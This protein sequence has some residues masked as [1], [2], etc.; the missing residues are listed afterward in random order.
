MTVYKKKERLLTDRGINEAYKLYRRDNKSPLAVTRDIYKRVI[1]ECNKA[2]L[3]KILYESA[4]FTLPFKLGELRIKKTRQIYI[5][6]HLKIDWEA[7]KKL[8]KRV[9]H[10]NEHRNGYRYRWLWRKKGPIVN[11][12]VYSYTPVRKAKR[13]LAYILKNKPQIDYFEQ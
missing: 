4:T 7:T 6:S 11:Q 3:D 2:M 5:K 13:T 10:L 1:R 9:Y 12:S 8:G